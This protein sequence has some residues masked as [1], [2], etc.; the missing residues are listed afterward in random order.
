MHVRLKRNRSSSISVIVV[1][2]SSGRYK[3]LYTVGIAKDESEITLLRQKGLE[4]IRQREL[5]M[6]P[7]PCMVRSAERANLK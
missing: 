6:H 4:W 1:D 7:E 2:K 3:E 5:E